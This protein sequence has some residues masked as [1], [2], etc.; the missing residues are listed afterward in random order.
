MLTAKA[1]EPLEVPH[2]RS[3]LPVCLFDKSYLSLL[4]ESPLVFAQVAFPLGILIP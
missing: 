4:H 1:E 2:P 3:P